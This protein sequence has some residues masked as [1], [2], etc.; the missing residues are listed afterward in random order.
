MKYNSINK[1]YNSLPYNSRLVCD[2]DS[3]IKEEYTKLQSLPE[4]KKI[5]LYKSEDFQESLYGKIKQSLKDTGLLTHQVDDL[6][7]PFNPLWQRVAINLSGGADSAILA[8]VIASIIENNGYTCTLDVITFNRCW[9]TRPW[10]GEVSLTVYN[11]LKNRFPDIIGDRQVT[12]IPP[13]LEHGAIGNLKNGKS[14]DQMLIS[15]FNTYAAF[16]KSY[17]AVYNATTKNPSV[18]YEIL[19]RMVNR[20]TDDSAHDIIDLAYIAARGISWSLEPL[21]YVEKDWVLSQYKNYDVL[22]LFE[23]TR[24]C[25]G[26]STHQSLIGKDFL[27]HNSNIADIPECGDCFW[28]VERNWAKQKVGI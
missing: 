3:I 9:A 23:V 22:D 2:I 17:R 16:S 26:D 18:D 21:R 27:G 28:C 1:L 24:S 25:E 13:E 12:Y 19:D 11:W 6:S 5:R 14:V 20:D 7:I 15:S 4:D 10:Q 8:Y